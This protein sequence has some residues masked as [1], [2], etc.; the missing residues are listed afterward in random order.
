MLA[1]P[2]TVAPT[3]PPTAVS[4]VDPTA[5]TAWPAALDTLLTA[6]PTG[7]VGTLTVTG[8]LPA[9]ESPRADRSHDQRSGRHERVSPR[10][11]CG[12]DP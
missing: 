9:S 5:E 1:T 12:S 10:S 6:D 11:T 4:A 7:A 3:L 8:G 2:A